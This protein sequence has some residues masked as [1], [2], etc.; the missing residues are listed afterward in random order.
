MSDNVGVVVRNCAAFGVDAVIVG[1]TA[2]SPWLRRA[3][4]NSMGTVFRMRILHMDSLARA[5]SDLRSRFGTR[6][7]ASDPDAAVDIYH[8][9][10]AHNVCIVFGSEDSG[11]SDDTRDLASQAV[12]IPM[13][14]GVDSLNVGSA[15]AVFLYEA[16]RQRAAGS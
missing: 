9:D 15:S 11:V 8:A 13:C 14:R 12:A 7:V 6:I 10:L 5:L 16:A 1:E 2:C 4:R 3:V